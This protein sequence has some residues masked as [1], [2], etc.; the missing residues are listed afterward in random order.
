MDLH[1]DGFLRQFWEELGYIKGKAQ[2]ADFAQNPNFFPL[3]ILLQ[4]F[5]CHFEFRHFTYFLGPQPVATFVV[6]VVMSSTYSKA[7]SQKSH[8]GSELTI[9]AIVNFGDC[10]EVVSDKRQFL[11]GR[12]F[13]IDAFIPFWKPSWLYTAIPANLFTESA[14]YDTP[15]DLAVRLCTYRTNN[16]Y[17]NAWTDQIR[18]VFG[19]LHPYNMKVVRPES[20]NAPRR[21]VAEF[22]AVLQ[23]Q[24]EHIQEYCFRYTGYCYTFADLLC[25]LPVNED[26]WERTWPNFVSFVG[27][28]DNQSFTLKSGLVD[29]VQRKLCGFVRLHSYANSPH[30][31]S[32]NT[33]RHPFHVFVFFPIATNPWMSFWKS[34][35]EREDSK[36]PF[37]ED[38]LLFASGSIVGILSPD[39]VNE[40]LQDHEQILIVVP[41]FHHLITPSP[42][43]RIAQ[44]PSTPR[45]PSTASAAGSRF[46]F[47]APVPLTAAGE[48]GCPDPPSSPSTA[49]KD[50]RQSTPLAEIS[51]SGGFEIFDTDG[52]DGHSGT[53]QCLFRVILVMC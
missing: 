17:S 33:G 34:V 14:D 38:G 16:T 42:A 25:R 15:A 51:T 7:P 1:G 10:Q 23:S 39:C 53:V 18:L 50:E 11:K 36:G 27:D 3:E 12:N 41:H 22:F 48:S 4:L 5:F 47:K 45:T 43:P 31:R 2:L 21:L 20:E 29:D 52:S 19:K 44:G 24:Q 49:I 28:I 35:R 40:R 37:Q 26:V 32:P 13:V 46:R 9:H 6:F 8:D 30:G